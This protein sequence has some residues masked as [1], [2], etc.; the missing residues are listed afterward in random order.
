MGIHMVI[1]GLLHS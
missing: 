1:S